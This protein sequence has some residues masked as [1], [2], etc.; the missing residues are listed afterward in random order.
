MIHPLEGY[1]GAL[2]LPRQIH[3]RAGRSTTADANGQFSLSGPF[4][5]TTRFRA[6]KEGHVAAAQVASAY[7]TGDLCYGTLGF[8]LPV[9]APPVNISGDYTL[10]FI[11][12]SACVDLPE[13]VRTR[14]YAATIAPNPNTNVPANTSLKVTLSGASFLGNYKGFE[15]GVAGDYFDFF[16]NGDGPPVVEQLPG[17]R[18][19][20]FNG[21]A[22]ATVAPGASTISTSFDGSIEYCATKSAMGS[23]YYGCGTSPV[24][25]QPIPGEVV[26]R[27]LCESKNHQLILTRR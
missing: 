26:T 4:D 20:A 8:Y 22:T 25:G 27:A 6:T 13:E 17:N 5:R 18:Y 24:T 7:C 21:D 23:I 9:L 10:T 14:T 16:L 15:I 1:A 19:V 3:E 12:D 2:H 11:A